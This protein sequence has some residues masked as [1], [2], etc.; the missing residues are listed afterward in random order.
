MTSLQPKLPTRQGEDLEIEHPHVKT[1]FPVVHLGVVTNHGM[2]I[3][4]LLPLVF[5]NT[6]EA[7][8][9]THP[10]KPSDFHNDLSC[11]NG[12]KQQVNFGARNVFFM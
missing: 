9:S 2:H 10:F 8:F 11:L 12:F 6:W 4:T 7:L 3:L 1:Y 5:I